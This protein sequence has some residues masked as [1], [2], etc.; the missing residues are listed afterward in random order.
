MKTSLTPLWIAALLLCFNAS[1]YGPVPPGIPSNDPYVVAGYLKA[2]LYSGVDPTGLTD[3]TAGLQQA[4][5]DGYNYGLAV[6][7][8]AGTYLVSNTLLREQVYQ[9][10]G[11]GEQLTFTPEAINKSPMLVGE[12]GATRPL[13]K[14][15]NSASGFNNPSSPKPVIHFKNNGVAGWEGDADC[16]FGFV[17][18]GLDI[19]LGT[20]NSG[21]VGI[22]MASAQYSTLEDVKITATGAYA[23]VR[24]TPSTNVVVNVEVD[25]GQYGIMPYTCCGISLIGIKL[26]NQTVAGLR[27][28][29]DY[30]AVMMTGFEIEQS[31]AVPIMNDTFRSHTAEMLLMDGVIKI[32]GAGTQPAI[33]NLNGHTM[34]MSNVYV[35]TPGLIAENHNGATVAG[36]GTKRIEEYSYTNNQVWTPS[37]S[38]ITHRAYTLIN[39]VTAQNQISVINTA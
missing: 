18:R 9:L 4:L 6:M 19:N 1:A 39:G 5:N 11:C 17:V 27:L 2:T 14:L 36:G 34:W 24:G 32:T 25:G 21:A 31:T 8:P 15:A 30:S 26:R 12:P 28:D 37:G 16:G 10:T 29:D 13:I 3:S 33:S 7:L 23:G 20:G 38:G 22:S 35:I